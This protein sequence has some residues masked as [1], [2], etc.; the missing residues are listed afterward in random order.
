MKVKNINIFDE[1]ERKQVS[2][3][4]GKNYLILILSSFQAYQPQLLQK[5][6]R[7]LLA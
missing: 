7:L 1:E 6:P 4:L 5:G 2:P 3:Q